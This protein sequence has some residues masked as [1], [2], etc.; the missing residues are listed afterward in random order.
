MENSSAAVLFLL[1][2]YYTIK[3]KM[4]NKFSLFE[5]LGTIG[6]LIGF[7]LLIIAPGN[8][9][10]A[11]YFKNNDSLLLMLIK[12]FI[13]VSKIFIK[14]HGFSL[15]L[16]SVF[17]GFDLV[18]HQKRKLPIFSFFY[19]LATLAGTYSMILSPIFP[20]RA[21]LIITVFSIITLGSILVHFEF[22]IPE[23]IKRNT[24]I[25]TV[26]ILI[27][28]C[29]SLMNSYK[30]II[31]VYLRWY[32]RYEYILAEKEKGNL[33]IEV[34]PIEITDFHVAL[35]DLGDISSDK[36]NWVN[37][38]IASYFGLKSIKSNDEPMESLWTDKGKRIKQLIIP[39]QKI[40]NKLR[41]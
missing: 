13:S 26:I 6:F 5:I 24:A 35:Y 30:K 31:G 3:I 40:I 38:S 18:Y 11:E 17:L 27:G 29:L 8:Y 23:I 14:N 28:L 36:N 4:K 20:D 19:L 1:I 39:P 34:T 7:F 22:R 9:I 2:A 37:A 21:F 25:L 16:I 32:D 10:R 33:E 12:R 15:V 41:E